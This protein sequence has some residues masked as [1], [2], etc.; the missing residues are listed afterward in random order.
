M[1]TVAPPSDF[2]FLGDNP[3]G[4]S[5]KDADLEVPKGETLSLIGGDIEITGGKLTASSGRI[6]IAS[7][8]SKGK[9]VSHTSD[10]GMDSFEALGKIDISQ[11]ANIDV[12]GGGG[13]GV[14]IRGGVFALSDGSI[15]NSSTTSADPGSDISITTTDSVSISDG[16][17][18]GSATSDHGN[19]GDIS[20]SASTLK[21]E[22]MDE[23]AQRQ[24]ALITSTIGDGNAGD[25]ELKINES[26]EISGNSRI[27]TSTA[28]LFGSRPNKGNAGKIS[29][30]SGSLKLR[31][32]A[33][34]DSS[35]FLSEGIGGNISI[36]TKELVTISG[37]PVMGLS[38]C[39][40]TIST[41]SGKS[42][43]IEI[44]T[45]AL[46][47]E[48]GC[49]IST[50]TQGDGNAGQIDL[51]IGAIK[52]T[53]GAQLT[54][55]SGFQDA[56]GNVIIGTGNAGKITVTAADSV[57]ISSGSWISSS[58]IGEGHG[59][60]ITITAGGP[61]SLSS[62]S[63]IASSTAGEGHAGNI[64]ITAGG[65]VSISDSSNLEQVRT[66][67]FTNTS[68]KG[69]AGKIFISSPNSSL[70][71]NGGSIESATSGDGN[72][73][74]ISLKVGSLELN[75]SAG[76]FSNSGSLDSSTGK[77]VAGQG[78]A[79]EIKVAAADLVSLSSGSL[80]SSS[81][82]EGSGGMVSVTTPAPLKMDE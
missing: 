55:E 76:I 22:S 49:K 59:E 60:E 32:G 44:F 64:T 63:R 50:S 36:T 28:Q 79:G 33:T 41:G 42:G 80:I 13:E 34:I 1:L 29:I 38:S 21:I 47:I 67:I 26:I 73:G 61:V 54:S 77:M 57:S 16:S 2:G 17:I 37:H 19:A 12:S 52:L 9:V 71:I 51:D 72:G 81:T 78:Q 39:I 18:V 62:L 3:A 15:I 31:D 4:I 20:I 69:D 75:D 5:I 7:A 23:N 65:P 11:G 14:F 40:S 24:S 43:N 46:K 35:S 66:A 30:E 53:N 48:D 25:I 68:G 70:I 27:F 82:V 56:L 58:T 74:E 45:S 6:N 8:S 10:L